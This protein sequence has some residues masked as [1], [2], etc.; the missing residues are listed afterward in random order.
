MAALPLRA[1]ETLEAKETKAE[2]ASNKGAAATAEE[3][4]LISV[5]NRKYEFAANERTLR[6]MLAYYGRL[7]G[8]QYF[9]S[10]PAVGQITVEGVEGLLTIGQALNQILA[11]TG[12]AFTFT[13]AETV[14]IHKA[15]RRKA[16]KARPAEPVEVFDSPIEAP[17]HEVLVSAPRTTALG[18]KKIS[19]TTVIDGR[20]LEDV[21]RT[22]IASALYDLPAVTASR[23]AENTVYSE[24]GPGVNMLDLRDLGVVRTLVVV[25]GRRHVPSNGGSADFIAV[26]VN[27]LPAGLVERIEVLTTGASVLY[28]ADAVG[29]LVNVTLR[30]DFEG[31][32][33]SMTT[34]MS[35][36]GDDGRYN[37]SASFG[38]PVSGGRGHY[39]GFLNLS[40][41]DGLKAR[42]RKISSDPAGFALDGVRTS[43][44]LG[45]VLTQGFGRAP[46]SAAGTVIGFARQNGDFSGFDDQEWYAIGDDG[47][48]AGLYTGQPE[49]GYNWA[50]HSDLIAPIDTWVYSGNFIYEITDTDQF[51]L[52]HTFAKSTVRRELAPTPAYFSGQQGTF[53]PIDNPYLPDALRTILDE[54]AAGD[55]SGIYLNRRIVEI[56]N[57]EHTIT[58][59]LIRFALGVE[60]MLGSNWDYSAHYQ[61]GSSSNETNG[62]NA[63]DVLKVA[64]S[65][66]P[67]QC[68]IHSHDGCFLTNYFGSNSILPF[69]ADFLKTTYKS[70]IT[71]YQHVLGLE[72]RGDL[73]S[74]PAGPLS[75]IAGLHYRNERSRARPDELIQDGRIGGVG[76][77]EVSFG[78]FSVF[79]NYAAFNLPVFEKHKFGHQLTVNAGLRYS[80]YSTVGSVASWQFGFDYEPIEEVSIRAS[81]QEANRAPNISELFQPSTRN[82]HYYADP[83]NGLGTS[84]IN[85]NVD[86]NCRAAVPLGGIVDGYT[87]RSVYADGTFSGNVALDEEEAHT[88]NIGITFRPEL[89]DRFGELFVSVDWF[90]ID[91]HNFIRDRSLQFVLNECYSSVNLSSFYCGN[92][93]AND[94][95]FFTRDPLTHEVI[96]VNLS[97]QNSGTFRAGGIDTELVYSQNLRHWGLGENAGKIRFRLLHSYNLKSEL[98]SGLVP[99]TEVYR[100][101]ISR[102][103]NKFLATVTYERGPLMLDWSVRFR[104]SGIVNSFVSENVDGNSAPAVSYHNLAFKYD[105]NKRWLVRGG[106]ENLFDKQ[107]PFLAYAAHNTFPEYYDIVGRSFYVGAEVKF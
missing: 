105:L 21:G 36:R 95:P 58:R 79:E 43:P 66:S 76:F 42:D 74:L 14:V 4:I 34:G 20:Y 8:L 106:I 97:L 9:Y 107:P 81:Y 92:N 75:V 48:L 103:T 104:G 16:V 3:L 99:D 96:D 60:G 80:H 71:N 11:G 6:A 62:T 26:D 78:D 47:D 84:G 49:Q 46:A 50:Q 27:V 12:F 59:G 40:R 56:G 25:N 64:Y 61:Y 67:L 94:E 69:Q 102:P 57:R 70:K 44:E 33:L 2:E 53:I 15:R 90:D 93:P 39:M 23:S 89:Q 30:E 85:D 22:N 19:P 32:D 37:L 54:Q 88:K 24:Y 87:Q 86:S 28:G 100:G 31:L 52:E 65:A 73:M 91:V 35:Q 63:V 98:T 10:D 1:E 83:C 68:G 55:V 101:S 17:V 72:F 77:S 82:R 38:R 41:E 29:G 45:G 51:F 13:D 5:E 18:F 7:T